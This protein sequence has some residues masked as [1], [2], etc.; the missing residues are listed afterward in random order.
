MFST[1][2]ECVQMPAARASGLRWRGAESYQKGARVSG[3]D[4][5]RWVLPS[6]PAFARV[7]ALIVSVLSMVDGCQV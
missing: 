3:L 7:C 6:V 5:L 1:P 4:G 2:A